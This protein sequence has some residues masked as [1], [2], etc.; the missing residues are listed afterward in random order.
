MFEKI[1]ELESRE[2]DLKVIQIPIQN[3]IEVEKVE[4]QRKTEEMDVIEV[5]V[6]VVY[7]EE[8]VKPVEK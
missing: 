3:K 4:R 2:M 1:K 8:V 5:P 6:E 7:K